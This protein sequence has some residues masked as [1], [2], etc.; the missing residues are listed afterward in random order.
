MKKKRTDEQQSSSAAQSSCSNRKCEQGLFQTEDVL[1]ESFSTSDDD[2]TEYSDGDFQSIA[3]SLEQATD[4]GPNVQGAMH[5]S[6]VKHDG[7][8]SLGISK[9]QFKATKRT[10]KFMFTPQWNF[11]RVDTIKIFESN[12]KWMPSP[13][14]FCIS[15]AFRL[16]PSPP[17]PST[18]FCHKCPHLTSASKKGVYNHDN[19]CCNDVL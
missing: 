3:S 7:H 10:Y 11:I 5:N 19:D 9:V 17:C 18:T 16:E 12:K 6:S 4:G 1:G 15:V 2:I 8:D 13:F 14:D